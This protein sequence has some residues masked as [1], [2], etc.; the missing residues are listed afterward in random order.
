MLRF[1][2]GGVGWWWS[3]VRAVRLGML[4]VVGCGLWVVSGCYVNVDVGLVFVSGCGWWVGRGGCA[5]V[6]G[7]GSVGSG[8]V[9]AGFV[10]GA[11][12]CL[13]ACVALQPL[14]GVFGCGVA[15]A[16]VGGGSVWGCSLA[17]MSRQ[18]MGSTPI[19][20]A[21]CFCAVR[22][23]A[24]AAGIGGDLRSGGFGFDEPVGDLMW[25]GGDVFR[26]LRSARPRRSVL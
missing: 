7:V 14:E 16:V 22:V 3:W 18:G 6:V 11:G 23:P 21:R 12:G 20:G 2:V 13:V 4:W 19:G 24:T 15:A 17:A 25:I 5:C 26:Q 9:G 10:A 8:L 1:V